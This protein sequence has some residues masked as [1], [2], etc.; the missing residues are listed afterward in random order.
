MIHLHLTDDQRQKARQYAEQIEDRYRK[1]DRSIR[2]GQGHYFAYLA[3]I[4]IAE[5]YNWQH[6]RHYDYDIIGKSSA[7]KRVTLD[8]KAKVR[9]VPPEYHFLASVCKYNASQKCDYYLFASMLHDRELWIIG[10]VEPHVMKQSSL[11]FKAGDIDPTDPRGYRFSAPCYCLRY[12][13][14]KEFRK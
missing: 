11:V 2:R 3:E 8:V 9:S 10:V 7:G 14:L 1:N 6:V 12:R 4:A 5:R 13:D